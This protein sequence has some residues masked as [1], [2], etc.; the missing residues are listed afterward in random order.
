MDIFV[1]SKQKTFYETSC[2]FSVSYQNKDQIVTVLTVVAVLTLLK[3]LTF[4]ILLTILATLTL[5]T[6]FTLMTLLTLLTHFFCSQCL[7]RHL[8]V[9]FEGKQGKYGK[10][11]FSKEVLK[12]N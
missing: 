9:P 2:R 10:T 3:I 4:L 6:L 5:L 1:C 11:L 7:N 12:T 8:L